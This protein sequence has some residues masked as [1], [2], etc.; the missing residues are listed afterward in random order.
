MDNLYILFDK[1]SGTIIKISSTEI[2]NDNS[3]RECVKIDEKKLCE[4]NDTDS[5]SR[6]FTDFKIFASSGKFNL[7]DQRIVTADTTYNKLLPILYIHRT[8]ETSAEIKLEITSLENKPVLRVKFL[9]DQSLKLNSYKNKSYVHLTDKNDVTVHY[10][11]FE[12]NLTKFDTDEL[13][14]DIDR[15]DYR[16]L[17][18][19]QISFYHRK[20]LNIVYTII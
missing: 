13:I 7:I 4:L 6:L 17:F 1:I 10:Q 11:T 18:A 5:I 14:F 3:D 19:N 15:C 9:G 2:E 8:Q 20:K 16:K 12:I